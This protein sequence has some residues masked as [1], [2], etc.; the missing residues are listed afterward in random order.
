MAVTRECP[1]YQSRY[2]LSGFCGL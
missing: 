1:V 2:W